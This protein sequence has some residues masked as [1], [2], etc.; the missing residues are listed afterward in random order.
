MAHTEGPWRVMPPDRAQ[1]GWI[2]GD[3]EGGSIADCEPPG[4]WMPGEEADANALLIAAAPDLLAAL[5]MITDQLERIGDNRKDA[6]FI[7][8]ARTAI[9]KACA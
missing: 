4:P 9:A 1:S 2:V 3:A 6:V 5:I 8:A 7:E